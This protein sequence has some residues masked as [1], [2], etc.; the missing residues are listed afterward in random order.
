[1]VP[2]GAAWGL[3]AQL[4]KLASGGSAGRPAAPER[5]LARLALQARLVLHF[6]LVC[7]LD[8]TAS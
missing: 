5:I 8:C 7:M 4:T 2:L 3:T 1:M 6:R